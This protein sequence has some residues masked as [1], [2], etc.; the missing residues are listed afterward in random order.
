MSYAR[1]GWEN[2]DVY[3][4]GCVLRPP[5]D[6]THLITCIGCLLIRDDE[7]DWLMSPSLDFETKDGILNHLEDHRKAGHVIPESA[8]EKI[9][10]DSWLEENTGAAK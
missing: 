8:I 3:L 4:V 2:S 6:D 1:W 5:P 10:E 7:E 9:K